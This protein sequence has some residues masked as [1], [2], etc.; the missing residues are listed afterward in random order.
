[1][2]CIREAAFKMRPMR[3]VGWDLALTPSG[4]VIIE[5]MLSL[6][7]TTYTVTLRRAYSMNLQDRGTLFATQI[8]VRH[9]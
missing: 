1:M 6:I 5:G 8:T 3:T 9:G 4:P 7:Q 2:D